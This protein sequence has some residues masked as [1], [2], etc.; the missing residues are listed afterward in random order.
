MNCEAESL[1]RGG[2]AALRRRDL[3]D[4]APVLDC[5]FIVAPKLSSG[6]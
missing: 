6:L 3:T 4:R 1:Q 2:V 5:R